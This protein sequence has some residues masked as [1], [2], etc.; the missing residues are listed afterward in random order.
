MRSDEGRQAER[1]TFPQVD[2]HLVFRAVTIVGWKRL[3]LAENVLPRQ[4]V[5]SGAPLLLEVVGAV[6]RRRAAE[7]EHPATIG[8]RAG[9][10]VPVNQVVGA[11]GPM[12]AKRRRRR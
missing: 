9:D 1:K 12:L 7:V 8:D 4:R 10:D 5:R 3:T 11:E 6:I 2:R